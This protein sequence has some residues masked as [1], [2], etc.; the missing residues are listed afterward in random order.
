MLD[1]ARRAGRRD[2]AARVA[3]VGAAPSQVVATLTGLVEGEW[4]ATV[5]L[6]DTTLVLPAN[7]GTYVVGGSVFVEV[8][9]TRRPVRVVAPA[10][11]PAGGVDDNGDPVTVVRVDH[12]L[13]P[14]SVPVTDDQG[15][16]VGGVNPDGTLTGVA[17]NI[18][19]DVT[20]DGGR[21]LTEWLTKVP[22]GTIGP[23]AVLANPVTIGQTNHGLLAVTFQVPDLGAR[24]VRVSGLLMAAST[25]SVQPV[26]AHVKFAAGS[27]VTTGNTTRQQID[28]ATNTVNRTPVPVDYTFNSDELG[29]APGSTLS[30]LLS[31]Q[32]G[33]G[34][35]LVV[36][37]GTTFLQVED[38]GAA[39]PT[40][41]IVTQSVD[42]TRAATVAVAPRTDVWTAQSWA[43]YYGT[44]AQQTGVDR[45]Y[46]GQSPYYPQRKRAA[47]QFPDLSG[48]LAG[49]TIEWVEVDIL[50]DH[51]HANSGGTVVV[52]VK[53]GA[54]PA[55]LTDANIG[56]WGLVTRH[57][58]RGETATIR[59][60]S[61]VH[62]GIKSGATRL[63]TFFTTS[64]SSEYYGTFVPGSFRIRIRH[65]K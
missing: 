16:Q 42:T 50:S 58:G 8:T 34:Q 1:A 13:P 35:T 30:V 40:N 24:Q 4:K 63:V 38:L 17:A 18:A 52:G 59:L 48:T 61:S 47:I 43:T 32:T 29:V 33:G 49:S 7:P 57:M 53:D 31:A 51:W 19:G 10:A 44:G 9:L 55:T 39:V 56:A 23:K 62:A 41:R 21:S 15:G 46:Q 26:A 45:M 5:V 11:V 64:T 65:Q 54:L 2:V 28:S 36:H 37:S 25:A 27:D 3:T 12:M 60:P 14:V 22:Q 20:F 6:D